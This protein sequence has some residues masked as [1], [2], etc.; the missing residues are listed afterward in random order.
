MYG[1]VIASHF[2]CRQNMVIL[3]QDAR[4]LSAV[5]VLPKKSPF[6]E[7]LFF[8]RA[9]DPHVQEKSGPKKLPFVVAIKF[10][11]SLFS[12]AGSALLVIGFTFHLLLLLLALLL[13]MFLCVFFLLVFLV[14]A[15]FRFVFL[16]R[17]SVLWMCNLLDTPLL[18]ATCCVLVGKVIFL[19]VWLVV[20]AH[21]AHFKAPLNS[22]CICTWRLA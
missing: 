11:M 12:V 18:D 7:T 21:V 20:A 19:D 14:L 15:F 1:R 13:R 3:S 5:V 10:L 22:K 6:G 8:L 2:H 16:L 9:R 17:A 4:H